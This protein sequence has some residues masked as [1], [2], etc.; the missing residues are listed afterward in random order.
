MLH[1]LG[2]RDRAFIQTVRDIRRGLLELGGVADGGYEAILMQGSGTFGIESVL[3]SI[4]PPSP[5]GKWL[6]LINGAYGERMVKIAEVHG[7]AYTALRF[8]EG[9]ALEVAA[10]R[11]ALDSD[12]A[13]THLAAVHC[14]TTTGIFNPVAE[15]GALAKMQHKIYFVDAMSSFGGV[16]LDVAAAGID[17]LVSSANKCIEGV[18]GFS[19]ALARREALLSTEGYARTLSL[20]LFAQWQGLEKDGQF[21]FTPPTHALLAFAQALQELKDEGGIPG[22]AARYQTNYQTILEGMTALGFDPYLPPEDRGYIITSYRY[23]D[24][25]RFDFEAFYQAL[26]ERGFVI[27]PGKVTQADCFRIGHIGRLYPADM[28]ALLAAIRGVLIEM[29][30]TLEKKA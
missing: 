10:I 26:S 18:P 30:I 1:D 5:N 25:P 19:F 22:R 14:E 27:Y 24:H 9:A 17:Y 15:I 3:S 11:A 8:P 29:D 4:T 2:S 7:L 6:F 16:P 12:P 20:N 13:I 28:A 23:P 21:R